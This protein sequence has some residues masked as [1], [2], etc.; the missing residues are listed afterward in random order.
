VAVNR[1]SD[2]QTD[3]AGRQTAGSRQH[4]TRF[5]TSCADDGSV[6]KYARNC[7]NPTSSTPQFPGKHTACH[8]QP[9]APAVHTRHTTHLNS[10]NSCMSDGLNITRA[11]SS[12]FLKPLRRTSRQPAG[13]L[14]VSPTKFITK[15]V[16]GRLM[17]SVGVPDCRGE[18]AQQW[19]QSQ[20]HNRKLRLDYV[21]GVLDCG[22]GERN[23]E[24]CCKNTHRTAQACVLT[25]RSLCCPCCRHTTNQKTTQTHPHTHTRPQNPSPVQ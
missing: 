24:T 25:L 15:G 4:G 12:L 22:Q 19:A 11:R 17:M 16:A 10:V 8:C 23:R 20:V 13:T 1:V 2:R 5:E 18:G 3:A 7:S 6:T 14:L 21:V 9:C